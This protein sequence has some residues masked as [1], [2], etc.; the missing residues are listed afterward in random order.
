MTMI[1]KHHSKKT[2]DKIRLTLVG[3]PLSEEHKEKI[4]LALLVRQFAK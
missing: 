2:K 1:G 3:I 4:H